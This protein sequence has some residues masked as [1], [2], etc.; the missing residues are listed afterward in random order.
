M[1]HE[2]L[3]DEWIAAIEALRDEAPEPAAVVKDVVINIVVSDTP[4]GEREMHLREGRLE[5]GLADGAPT[6]MT[7]PHDVAEQLFITQDQ[8]AVTQ[9]F[10]G[11]KIKVTGDMM[12]LMKLQ[13]APPPTDEQ[14]AFQARI[15]ELTV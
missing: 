11:G 8:Q 6:T 15:R 7:M 5:Q 1:A 10:M 9:A 4:Y 3:S 2:F 12:V 14:E 13:T